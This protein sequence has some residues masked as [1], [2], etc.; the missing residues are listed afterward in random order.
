MREKGKSS[1]G[2]RIGGMAFSV[3]CVHEFLKD[4]GFVYTVRGYCMRDMK[5]NVKGIGVCDRKR[6]VKRNGSDLVERKEDLKKLVKYSGFTS[7]DDWWDAING[8]CGGRHKWCYFVR[9][10]NV[11]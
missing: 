3:P 6:C 5:V 10:K 2:S 11:E 8:F 9:V 4:K 7:L 1:M